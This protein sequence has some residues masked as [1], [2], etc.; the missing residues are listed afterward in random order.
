MLGRISKKKI[1]IYFREK[2][3][4]K[5]TANNFWFDERR[6]IIIRCKRRLINC[7]EDSCKEDIISSIKASISFEGLEP[8]DYAVNLID[9]YAD[10]KITVEKYI[11]KIKEKYNIGS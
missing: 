10:G 9:Q 3:L 4:C 6:I 2:V 11:A 7:Y 5:I 8:S 1:F